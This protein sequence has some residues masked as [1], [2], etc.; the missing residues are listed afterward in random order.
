MPELGR[1]KSLR[2]PREPEEPKAASGPPGGRE[3]PNR[4]FRQDYHILEPCE[5]QSGSAGS[6]GANTIGEIGYLDL[7]GIF[8]L[9]S[10]I[11]GHARRSKDNSSRI[12]HVF[13]SN[14]TLHAHAEML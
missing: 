4:T 7:N 6:T 10:L 2:A 13:D 3:S 8:E 1:V 9:L 12:V 11:E 5:D 14:D